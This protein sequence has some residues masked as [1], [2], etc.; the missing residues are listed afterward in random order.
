MIGI[1]ATLKIQEGKAAEFEAVF[2][3]LAGR[4]APTSRATCSTS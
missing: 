4:C 2:K 3:E 1:V